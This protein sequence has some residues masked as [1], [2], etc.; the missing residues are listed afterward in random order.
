VDLKEMDF[1]P[2]G[3]W[4]YETKYD[5]LLKVLKDFSFDRKLI[6]D[7][8]AGS[9]FF[10]MKFLDKFQFNKGICFDVNYSEDLESKPKIE[11]TK[12]MPKDKGD[13]ILLIDVLEHV[14]NE[15]EVLQTLPLHPSSLILV[16]VPAF[17]FLWSS[18]DDFLDHKRRY[19][20][21]SLKSVLV[22]N[23]FEILSIGYIF[24]FLFFPA[25]LV[26]FLKKFLKLDKN[27]KSDMKKANLILNWSLIKILNF[28]LLT[29]PNKLLGLSVVAVARQISTTP[30]EHTSNPKVV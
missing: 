7:V 21:N 16:T 23:N 25:L 10:C 8:G 26:R 11:F 19:T 2:Q 17:N 13:L 12:T 28:E 27:D 6:I 24:T 15:G 1:D 22:K 4:Y 18:H 9:G 5:L 14:D 20:K 30:K 29:C 3:H